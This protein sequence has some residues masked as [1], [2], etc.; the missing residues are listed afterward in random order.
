MNPS[1]FDRIVWICSST[2]PPQEKEK[3][4]IDLLG[5]Q[6]GKRTTTAVFVS[7]RENRQESYNP[8]LVRLNSLLEEIEK[9]MIMASDNRQEYD[10]KETLLKKVLYTPKKRHAS[11]PRKGKVK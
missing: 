1:R 11:K 2:L 7:E 9:V 6:K 10:K 3:A 8:D 5:V 4:I